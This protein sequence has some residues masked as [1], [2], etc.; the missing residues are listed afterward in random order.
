M[1]EDVT[2]Q[3]LKRVWKGGAPTK[4][5]LRQGS[6]KHCLPRVALMFK[7]HSSP[8]T[9]EVEPSIKIA[10]FSSAQ[11]DARMHAAWWLGWSQWSH[12][13]CRFIWFIWTNL[14]FLYDLVC[15]FSMFAHVIFARGSFCVWDSGWGVGTWWGNRIC[16]LLCPSQWLDETWEQPTAVQYMY[17]DCTHIH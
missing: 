7:S 8:E 2:C 13:L 16:Y 3:F 9:R 1:F 15:N 5:A 17:V 10:C 4:A 12:N 6:F 11:M 14:G